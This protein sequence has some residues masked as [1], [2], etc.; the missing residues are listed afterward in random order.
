MVQKDDKKPRGRPRAYNPRQ[1]LASA[2]E[3]FWRTGYTGT[4]LDDLSAAMG[5][6]RPSL[7]GAFGDKQALYLA[8]LDAYISAGQQA[9]QQLLSGDQPLPLA[10]VRVY[11]AAM[12]MYY[13][14]GSEQRGCFLIGTAAVEAVV[15]EAVR[16]RLREGLHRFDKAFEVCMKQAQIRGELV[17]DAD[18]AVLAKIASAILHTLAVR[19]RAGDSRASLRVTARAGVAMICGLSSLALAEMLAAAGKQRRTVYGADSAASNS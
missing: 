14:L 7:Y 8:T 6:N 9:M 3:A 5:M 19:S 12:D 10:L 16:T 18:T 13:P 1:V 11:E 2:T 17:A 15:D 4:S